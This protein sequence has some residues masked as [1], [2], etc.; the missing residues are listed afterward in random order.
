LALELF[1]TTVREYKRFIIQLPLDYSK[2][3]EGDLSD[4]T[5]VAV[6]TRLMLLRK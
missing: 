3:L 1:Q 2:E 4:F 5:Y 6:H